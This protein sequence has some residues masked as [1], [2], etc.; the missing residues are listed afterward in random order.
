LGTK[1]RI[2]RKLPLHGFSNK[3]TSSWKKPPSPNKQKT[4]KRKLRV[5]LNLHFKNQQITKR[6]PIQNE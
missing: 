1:D 3:K 5:G 2:V 4:N 6:K